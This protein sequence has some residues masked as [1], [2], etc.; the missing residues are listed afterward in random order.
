MAHEIHSM[1]YSI[2]FAFLWALHATAAVP[3]F[4][5]RADAMIDAYAHYNGKGDYGYAE[6][7]A[8]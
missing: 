6:I 3:T 2:L 8:G 5:E 7:A 4:Q 1:R